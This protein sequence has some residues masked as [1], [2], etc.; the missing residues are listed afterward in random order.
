MIE[1]RLYQL[2]MAI[3]PMVLGKWVVNGFI[4]PHKKRYQVGGFKHFLFSPRNL[5]KMNPI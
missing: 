5:G 1:I 3:P 2:R 4:I